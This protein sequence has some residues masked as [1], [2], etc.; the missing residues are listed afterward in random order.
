VG[1]DVVDLADPQNIGKSGDE[2]FCRRVF[3]AGELALVGGSPHPD[4][5]LWAIWA[6]KEAAYKAVSRIDD[7]LCSIPRKYPVAL[8]TEL[9]NSVRCKFMRGVVGTP[10]GDIPVRICVE[11]DALHAIAAGTTAELRRI[12]SRVEPLPARD[13]DA[14]RFARKILIEELARRLDCLVEE[15]AVLK[16]K[17]RPW[18]PYVTR[19]GVRLPV[20]ISLSHDGLFA[21]FAFDPE[22]L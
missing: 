7:S 20:A 14:G 6:A 21:A 18:P 5:M 10:V 16:E 15:L 13:T 2:R 11:S 12:V 19:R 22:T 9:L 17:K 8:E 3:N 1:N 4:T